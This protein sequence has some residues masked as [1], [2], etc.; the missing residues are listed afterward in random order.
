[1]RRFVKGKHRKGVSTIIAVILILAITVVLAGVLYI[2][3]SSLVHM[4]NYNTVIIS[5]YSTSPPNNYGIT[6]YLSENITIYSVSGKI[7][8]EDVGFEIKNS[9]GKPFYVQ[10]QAYDYMQVAYFSPS[11]KYIGSYDVAGGIVLG[12]PY[13]CN[14]YYNDPGTWQWATSEPWIGG[15]VSNPHPSMTDYFVA[16]GF[17]D[18]SWSNSTGGA[19]PQPNFYGYTLYVIQIGG[20]TPVTGSIPLQ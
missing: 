13:S 4:S 10:N 5:F 8:I 14:S 9:Y 19:P 15:C 16:G 1:M 7:P 2:F 17:L 18:I 20:T 6:N 3:A 11:G 12:N